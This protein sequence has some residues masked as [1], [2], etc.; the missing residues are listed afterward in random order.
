MTTVAPAL[1]IEE[2]TQKSNSNPLMIPKAI[3]ISGQDRNERFW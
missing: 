1:L 3:M 2:R